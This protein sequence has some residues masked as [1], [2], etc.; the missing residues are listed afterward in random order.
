ME[1]FSWRV[2]GNNPGPT[3]AKLWNTV[4]S[5]GNTISEIGGTPFQVPRYERRSLIFEEGFSPPYNDVGGPWYR[6]R[7]YNEQGGVPY[8][9]DFK[10][11]GRSL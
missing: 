8:R 1:I 6:A 2:V 9:A 4:P 11:D 10:A 5:C 3:A 7:E